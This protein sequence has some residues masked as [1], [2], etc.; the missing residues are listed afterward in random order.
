MLGR[1]FERVWGP[2]KIEKDKKREEAKL[3]LE[4]LLS[5]SINLDR[6]SL[7]AKLPNQEINHAKPNKKYQKLPKDEIDEIKEAVKRDG[8]IS[9]NTYEQHKFEI[10]SIARNMVNLKDSLYFDNGNDK[11]CREGKT[12]TPEQSARFPEDGIYNSVNI[13]DQNLF[14]R[15]DYEG[16]LFHAEFDESGNLQSYK[17][18]NQIHRNT[19]EVRTVDIARLATYYDYPVLEEEKY[20]QYRQKIEKFN[21]QYGSRVVI[22]IISDRIIAKFNANP[23]KVAERLVKLGRKNGMR[24]TFKMEEEYCSVTRH[25]NDSCLI[26]SVNLLL[27][28][29]IQSNIHEKSDAKKHQNSATIL[30]LTPDYSPVYPYI[31]PNL[32]FANDL[33]IMYSTQAEK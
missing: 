13:L 19:L 23:Q 32:S 2:S 30:E 29:N 20:R 28:D 31:S 26:A 22:E 16:I 17:I 14:N 18:F 5:K 10:N 6:A 3:L 11:Y 27:P 15:S 21:M 25:N 12:V 1:M 9:K 7:Y 4:E 24:I 8:G 33:V